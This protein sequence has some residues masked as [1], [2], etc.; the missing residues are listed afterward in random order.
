MIDEMAVWRYEDGKTV[1]Y[2]ARDILDNYRSRHYVNPTLTSLS[3]MRHVCRHM[4]RTGLFY[5]H[6]SG[7]KSGSVGWVMCRL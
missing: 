6:P 3:R 5:V 4:L 1:V 2:V 7:G